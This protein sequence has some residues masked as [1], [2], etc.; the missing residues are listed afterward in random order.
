M[1]YGKLYHALITTDAKIYNMDLLTFVPGCKNDCPKFYSVYDAYAG[2]VYLKITVGQSL[3]VVDA[4]AISGSNVKVVKFPPNVTNMS[5]YGNG[6]AYYLQDNSNINSNSYAIY[7]WNAYTNTSVVVSSTSNT[8]HSFYKTCFNKGTLYALDRDKAQLIIW[9][10]SQIKT[11]QLSRNNLW[12]NSIESL[13]WNTEILDN[14]LYAVDRA[15]SLWE[16]SLLGYCTARNTP[17]WPTVK[18][19]NAD[20]QL[21]TDSRGNKYYV[22]YD[23]SVNA[24]HLVIIDSSRYITSTDIYN[25]VNGLQ[26]VGLTDYNLR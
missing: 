5:F 10:N 8:P 7:S 14:S 20:S 4:F 22:G 15:G 23:K 25:G 9:Q 1:H 18:S 26:W 11:V 16:I 3:D 13:S 21:V 2:I 12:V 6:T 24:Y 19:I 17:Q